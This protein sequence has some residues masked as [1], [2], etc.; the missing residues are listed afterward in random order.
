MS[1]AN[2]NCFSFINEKKMFVTSIMKFTCL[3]LY[4]LTIK[5]LL[6]QENSFFNS[7]STYINSDK[8]CRKFVS[9]IILIIIRSLL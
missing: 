9:F 7:G 5:I 3:D 2:R 1:N 6:N 4:L 8:E